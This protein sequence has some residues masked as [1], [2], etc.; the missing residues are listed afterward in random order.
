MRHSY[1][2]KNKEKEKARIKA[3]KVKRTKEYNDFKSSLKCILCGENHP[4]TIQFH[5]L[6]PSTKDFGISSSFLTKS[7]ARIKKELEKCVVLCANCHFKEHYELKKTG[8]SLLGIKK[9]I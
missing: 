4:S 1:Y 3:L 9:D 2:E 7:N 8:K 6:D 5:H